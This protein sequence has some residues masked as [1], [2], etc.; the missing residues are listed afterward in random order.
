[1]FSGRWSGLKPLHLFWGGNTSVVWGKLHLSAS[2][3]S[4]V[5]PDTY[6]SYYSFIRHRTNIHQSL[7]TCSRIPQAG[8]AEVNRT[9]SLCLMCK[10]KE[11]A[12]EAG[13]AKLSL[14]LPSR[15]LG[16]CAQVHAWVWRHKLGHYQ[17]K[18]GR[19]SQR[20]EQG[21]LRGP[22]EGR[23]KDWAQR[24]L[25]FRERANEGGWTGE[26]VSMAEIAR[27]CEHRKER[28]SDLVLKEW[29]RVID[30]NVWA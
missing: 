22:R 10:W 26:T 4:P 25:T 15:G 23:T 5:K 1:M 7:A 19:W 6:L 9:R 30:G 20:A 27:E 24:H 21:H 13:K 29:Y 11:E 14:R 3:C 12:E 16:I 17:H 18:D 2:T 28:E 8:A